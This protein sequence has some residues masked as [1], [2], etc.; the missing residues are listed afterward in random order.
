MQKRQLE[1]N[2]IPGTECT[3]KEQCRGTIAPL[4]CPKPFEICCSPYEVKSCLVS[5]SAVFFLAVQATFNL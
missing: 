3:V 4:D 2:V 1:C 5:F